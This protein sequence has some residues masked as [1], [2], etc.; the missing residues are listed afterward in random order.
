MKTCAAASQ[1]TN[2]ELAIQRSDTWG[3]ETHSSKSLYQPLKAANMK[4]KA[5]TIQIKHKC[6]SS[7]V[8]R[9]LERGG[10]CQQ[11]RKVGASDGPG[12]PS[13]SLLLP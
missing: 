9:N 13:T 12:T 5:S 10:I 6:L 8:A 3:L 7:P 4:S 1:L 11:Q 2:S